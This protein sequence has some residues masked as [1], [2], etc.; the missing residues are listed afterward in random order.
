MIR[1]LSTHGN[2]GVLAQI[3]S[4]PC[5][6]INGQKEGGLMVDFY[7]AVS[8]VSVLSNGERDMLRP[9]MSPQSVKDFTD[10]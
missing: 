2:A 1:S 10:T 5:K 8:L 9:I 3:P 6:N 7:F 4:V